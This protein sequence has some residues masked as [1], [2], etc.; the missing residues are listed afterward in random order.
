MGIARRSRTIMAKKLEFCY[1][2]SSPWTYLAFSRI[3]DVAR[4]HD[5]ELVGR[6]ILVGGGFNAVNPSVHEGREHPVKP[7]V[8][9]YDKDLQAWA[10]LNGLKLGHPTVFPLRSAN[11]LR[12]RCART[13]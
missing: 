8:R 3:E 7:K 4:R 12:G 13:V 11:A 9:Y 6:P 5:A 1:D 10:R 2:C